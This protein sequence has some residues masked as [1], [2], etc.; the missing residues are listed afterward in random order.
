MVDYS[1]GISRSLV[2]FVKE[3]EYLK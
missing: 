1:V 3:H 2:M